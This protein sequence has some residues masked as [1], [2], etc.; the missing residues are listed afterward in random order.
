M[1][2]PDTILKDRYQIQRQLGSGGQ[3]AVYEALDSS[4]SCRVAIKENTIELEE[5]RQAFIREAK[6]LANL[7]HSAFP[8]VTD[9]FS[10]KNVLYI[11]MEFIPGED[12][13]KQM[14]D[15][16][17]MPFPHAKV[18]E[19]ADVLLHA[20]DYLHSLNP[21]DPII[22]RD[23][24]PGNIKLTAR[25]EIIL[26]DFGLARG[27]TGEM[28]TMHSK[29]SVIGYTPGYGPPEQS[30]RHPVW[31]D[32]LSLSYPDQLKRFITPATD[33]RSD[34]YSLAATLYRLMTGEIP[35][36]G[37]K[38]V[39]P[40]WSGQADPLRPANQINPQISQA[41]ADVLMQALALER[42]E[43]F[44]SAAEMRQALLKAIGGAQVADKSEAKNAS[45]PATIPAHVTDRMPVA[46]ELDTRPTVLNIKYGILGRCDNSVRSVSFSPDGRLLAS[47]SN[48]NAVRL[49]DVVSGEARVLGQGGV[50]KSGFSYVSAIAFSPDG[51][52]VVGVGNDKTI[53]LWQINSDERR[54]LGKYHQ[55]LRSVAFS[56]DGEFI[57]CG[58]SDGAVQLWEIET[59]QMTILGNCQGIVWSV[60]ISPDGNSAAAESDD[61]NIK[62]WNLRSGL[63]GSLQSQ[64]SDLRS[65]VFSPD[66]KRI[67]AGGANQQIHEW[68]LSTGE[69]H[70]IGQCNDLIRSIAYSPDARSIASASDDRTVRIWN[71]ATKEERTLGLCDDVVSSIAFSID[72]RTVAT[73]SW[74]NTVRLWKA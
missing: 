13:E 34:L 62:L 49:W 44:S 61:K 15:R 14:I 39:L 31:S 1:L 18:L 57:I 12:L 2:T 27:S 45:L 74:D 37:P 72:G 58:G 71:I 33:A 68:D 8:K 10:Q 53:R 32:A 64:E 21:S 63:A 3:G 40:V 50:G 51:E 73:G 11:V 66:G 59:E 28:S 22:H 55:P 26:L 47:G 30:L 4:L 60:A 43:R 70:F 23:I 25:N 56:P 16:Q 9:F 5:Y 38:R 67:A 52:S 54:I 17:G 6:L 65:I 42:D 41:I 69:R 35:L 20:L 46:S 29:R 24:K 19:W 48:D 7:R 36:D